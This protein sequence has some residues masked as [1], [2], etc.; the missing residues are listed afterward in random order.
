MEEGFIVTYIN[1]V[2][3]KDP[4]SLVD[5]LLKIRG[6]VYIEGVTKDGVK[7]YYSYFF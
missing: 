3:I 5:I 6:R 7:G 1:K 2:P 4:E